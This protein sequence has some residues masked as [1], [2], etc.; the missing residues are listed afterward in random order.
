M[1]LGRPFQ[2]YHGACIEG[3]DCFIPSKRGRHALPRWVGEPSQKVKLICLSRTE[4]TKELKTVDPEK[5]FVMVP[6]QLWAMLSGEGQEGESSPEG[7]R[8][9][10]NT[11]KDP[12]LDKRLKEAAKVWKKETKEIPREKGI[13][14]LEAL[15]KE[16]QDV[17]P[18]DLPAELPPEREFSMKIPI[19][20]GS[21]TPN[22]APYRLS[23]EA[24]EAVR[25]ILKYLY[26]HGLV[27][28]SVSEFAAP[29]TLAPKPDG[30]WR[31]CTDYRRLNAI[32]NEAKYP[33]PRIDDSLDNLGK[34]RYYSKIDLRSGYWQVRIEESDIP[35]TAFRTPFGHH[36]WLVMPFG[37]QGAPSVFQRMMNHYL[38]DFLGDFVLCY[39][40][41]ILIYSNTK[42][43]HL[44]H[45]KKVL[46][47]LRKRKLLAKGTKCD[48]FRQEVLFLGFKVGG[49]VIDKDPKK[50]EAVENW[51]IPE[52]VRD[53]RSFLGLAGF[54]RKFINDFAKTARP[55]TDILK[56]TEFEEK[57]GHPFKKK[58]HVTLGKDEIQ[59]FNE[60]KTALTTSPCLIIFDPSKPTE[61]WA[62]ASWTHATV[63][64]VLLQ[65]H[66]QGLQPVAYLSRVLQ[67]A[68]SRY[69]TFEQ[70]L[71][72]LKVAFEEW[73][74]YLLPLHFTARTDHNGLK[75]LK[76]QKNLNERQWHWLAF[77]SEY[78][79]D[80][81][82]RPGKQMVVPDAL[83]RKPRT[84]NDIQEL[85]RVQKNED[86][87]GGLEIKIQLKNGK[88]KR[89]L[90]AL[91][92]KRRSRAQGTK[93][94]Q[95]DTIPEIFD[96]SD[97]PDYGEIFKTLKDD[98]DTSQPSL[99]LYSIRRGNLFWLDVNLQPRIC[100]PRKYR[101]ALLQEF[102]D[103][104][105]GGHFGQ[106]KTYHAIRQRYIWPH[107]RHHVEQFVL[108]CDSCQK[109][110]A[111]H[112]GSL[113]T[114]QLP[115][116]PLEPWARISI[117]FCGPLPRTKNGNDNIMGVICNLSREVIL[118][119]CTT[120]ISAKGTAEAFVERV[121]SRAGIPQIINSDRGPQFIAKFWKYLWKKLG[122][123][124]AL[125]A[126]YHPNSNPYIERQNKSFLE[127]LKSFVNT[128]HDDW[129]ECVIPY[130]FAYNNSYNPSL[131]DTPF[132]LNHG[133]H[134]AMPVVIAHK[135]PSPAV[136]DFVLNLQN[137]IAAARDHIKLQQAKRA[138]TRALKARN[139]TFHVGD[140]VL[141]ST[142]HYNLQ[143]QSHK[144]QP[145]WLGP[146]K[147]VEIRGPNTV[148][149]EVPP[150]LK[151]IEPIQN[152]QHLKPYV[153][154]PAAIRPTSVPQPP[155]LVDDG[156]EFEVEEIIAHRGSGN[157]TQ[158][159]VRF[160]TYGPEDD[161]WLPSKNLKNAPDIVAAYWER[162]GQHTTP[163]DAATRRT[164]QSAPRRLTRLGHVF[165]ALQGT[166]MV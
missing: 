159:L 48:F 53:V 41:D 66:G 112:T 166:A 124:V 52:T 64:A 22:Q 123:K 90:F 163:P 63:G 10:K 101:V 109:N 60:L 91:H 44:E 80:L 8:D 28:D 164:R 74:H 84:E 99:S 21:G 75:Y 18:E 138:D 39:L 151:R 45:I 93:I 46:E 56:S 15:L 29:I 116:V 141:L 72:A 2:R 100:V 106:D 65:N 13:P 111:S 35:K 135:T 62:D 137:R 98:E 25:E 156:K 92:S 153:S 134:A 122:T 16:Y 67:G 143:L 26:E 102:H 160:F 131:G 107:Q 88:S 158:F 129:E 43:E 114:P 140:L 23:T 82:Y 38:R 83:S 71:L 86:K 57:F 20:P 51:P 139:T 3:D 11:H 133:R 103:T 127:N 19:K 162:Q 121:L 87:D 68:E 94:L 113:G 119:P 40:D 154:R 136:E 118:I 5:A 144:L 105:L 37:L 6:S 50:I 59:A 70:E 78:Q 120:T 110:K 130:E 150:R 58:A 12:E 1:I 147:I 89:V 33:L 73:R 126:P 76:T 54:Y 49:G 32:T 79:F 117:D 142:E 34:A 9:Y 42:E 96:Y 31:F 157:K 161:L 128:R 145:R 104:P 97:D 36:E 27:Q 148:M 77:F 115:E 165:S 7:E 95:E 61:V 4:M 24:Q 152:V 55:L 125:S 155:D 146:L 14:E 30:T 108:S 85:L 17:F 47:V 69:A 81:L 149:I 132:F